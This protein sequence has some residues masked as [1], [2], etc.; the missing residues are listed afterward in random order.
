MVKT[1]IGFVGVGS[2]GQC[3]HLKNYVQLNQCRV[4]AI[5]EVKTE[6]AR[7]V[8]KRYGVPKVYQNHRQMLENEKLDAIVASQ[9]FTRHGILVPELAEAGI[10]VFTEKPLA[11][12]IETGK[13][14]L[15]AI[16]NAGIWLM[17]GYHKLSDPAAMFVMEEICRLKETGE[18]GELKYVRILMPEGDWVAEGFSD[19]I[20]TEETPNEMQWD[21]APSDMDQE[22]YQLYN[23]FVNYYIHQV[24][25][26]RN[27]LG[28]PYKVKYADPA[29]L[30]MAVEGESGTV[31]TIEMTPYR[32]TVGWEESALIAFE[33]GYIRLELPAPLAS[34]RAGTVEL[35]RDPGDGE[36][37]VRIRPTMPWVHAMKQQAINFIKA[38]NGGIE[39][40]CE[41][42]QAIDDLMTAREYIKL[43]T[44]K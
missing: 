17:V 5:A 10:P 41:A 43:K 30:L 12:S 28:E 1:K 25:L 19:L 14:I 15:Q 34:N 35:Y 4:A 36:R 37:P 20:M 18:L 22:T 27:L 31:G 33:R 39:P 3:A 13:K 40:P 6:Q 38:V 16:D 2:M 7:R 29:G 9:P 42:H 8:A 26:M 21:P 23:E 24:N 11:G 44:G 32:T